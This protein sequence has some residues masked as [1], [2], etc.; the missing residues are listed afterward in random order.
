MKS[1]LGENPKETDVQKLINLGADGVY[2]MDNLGEAYVEITEK[3][4]RRSLK[5]NSK[6]YKLF[7][8]QRF[9]NATG[10]PVSLEALKQ[11]AYHFESIATFDGK[12]RKLSRR[13]ALAKD[14]R[15]VYDLADSQSG[16]V[17][18]GPNGCRAYKNGPGIFHRT[19]NTAPQVWP[20]FD[21]EH[22]LL[23][24]LSKHFRT[25]LKKDLF[26]LA[27]YIVSCFIPEM[28]HPLLVLAGEK[29]AA[30]STSMRMIR[31]IVDP[32]R[33]DLLSMPNS[34]DNLGIILSN[35]YMPGFDNLDHLSPERSD[36]LCMAATGGS[37]AKRR[38][39]TDDEEVILQLKRCVMLNGINIVVTRSDLLDRSIVIEFKRIPPSER[40]DEG[41]VWDAFR[42]DLPQILGS[43]L[44]LLSKAM[45]IFPQVELA[46]K[47]RMADFAKWG[48]AIAEAMGKPGQLFLRAYNENQQCASQEILHNNPV[49]AALL[50]LMEDRREWES[51]PTTLYT[52]LQD[53]CMRNA[54]RIS[55]RNWPESPNALTRRMNNLR[56][57][58][59][60]AGL[61]FESR[62]TGDRKIIITNEHYKPVSSLSLKKRR[63]GKMNP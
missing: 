12:V 54:I 25:Q 5:V 28:P 15:I 40:K 6:A 45:A 48:Y 37:I 11:A 51:S 7:L 55:G 31:A 46:E 61:F 3:N 50:K 9:Y 53:V 39:Y 2:F 43:C 47:P 32:A 52:A 1:R 10:K 60:Q 30:K 36:L 23:K 59:E 22:D 33:T 27:V 56:S 19:T 41:E 14:G 13:V 58:L 18:I 62:K 24:L 57:N 34:T 44:L 21:E 35:N 8:H 38:L 63:R 20:D 29:G 42:K 16:A 4:V 17:I 49:A 26:L